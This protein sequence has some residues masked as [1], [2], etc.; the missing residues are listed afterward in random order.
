MKLSQ[1]K[2]QRSVLIL[3]LGVLG[4]LLWLVL[5]PNLYIFVQS[6][7]RGGHFTFANYREFFLNPSQIEALRNSLLIS[8]GSVVLS[9]V[10]GVPLAFIF[11][12]YDFPARRIF[13][14]LASL[15]VLL[16][17]LVGVISF[18][19][20]YGESGILSRSLQ[21]GLGLKEPPIALKGAWAI[22][23]VHAY[24]M[25]VYFYLFVSAGLR[26]LDFSLVEASRSLGASRVR[27][28]FTVTLRLL[29]PALIGAS[30]LTFM[31]SMASFSAP[32][33][34]GG[35]IRVL[36]LQIYNSKLNGDLE[37]ALVET[38]I[39]TAT[40]IFFLILL[41]RYE[42]T[43]LY[44]SVSKGTQR[45]LEVIQR[46]FLRIVLGFAGI[47]IVLFLL[48]PHFTLILVSFSKDG[49]WT[50]EILPP[51]YTAE[52]Y[53]RLFSSTQFLEPILNSLKMAVLATAGNAIFA[54]L[55]GYLIVRKRIRGGLLLGS[56]ILLPWALPG[57]VL[58]LS[59]ATT[60]NQYRP[61]QGR[62]LLVGTYWIL[63]LAYFIRN[64]PVVVRSVQA[65]FVQFDPALEEAARS[66]GA[67]W[68]YGFRRV[69]LPMVLPGVVS[70]SLL[71]FVAALGEFVTSIVIYTIH[72]RP[73][74]IEILA[75]LRQFNF[76]SAAAYGV[77][78][79]VMIAV[80]FLLSEKYSSD[81]ARPGL[82]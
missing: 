29:T 7:K 15:P 23:F 50:T 5:Y 49:T 82:G 8:L 10:V 57:T 74:S 1:Q 66:L 48:L 11:H 63:P 67:T 19:F 71:A 60:F 78:L 35:G 27:T 46:R 68:L 32:Y 70:G 53:G 21:H 12:F 38:V 36:A 39:L 18:M 61:L 14:G 64:I 69:V 24:T 81:S 33:I 52:N 41:R 17:P 37:M 80:V 31:T 77:L 65:S 62:L 13:A 42:G 45:P 73:I 20:L 30:V 4:L 51:S 44:R 25:Y 22:L 16:P 59:L 76:G 3:Y 9:A 72:N 47:L 43:D 55:A 6:L 28:F 79:V 2:I 56:L 58:G 40:S 34:F 26:R 54:L 75:Q